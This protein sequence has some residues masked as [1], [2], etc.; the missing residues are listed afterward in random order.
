M[1]ARQYRLTQPQ[2]ISTLDLNK[3]VSVDN[4][5]QVGS[6]KYDR[7]KQVLCRLINRNLA[8]RISD[9]D[10]FMPMDEIT[11]GFAFVKLTNKEDANHISRQL[12]N[13][14][15]DRT[16]SL[17]VIHLEPRIEGRCGTCG[18][19]FGTFPANKAL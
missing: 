18:S 12:N 13:Y 14:A 6:D 1:N 15:L 10:I 4:L 9:D 17:K 8:S 19:V 3:Y 7:L 11:Y 2:L 5:P 16:H